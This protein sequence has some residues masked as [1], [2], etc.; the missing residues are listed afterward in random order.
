[1]RTCTARKSGSN[2]GGVASTCSTIGGHMRSPPSPAFAVG[3]V[4]LPATDTRARTE[5]DTG[6][7][8][9]ASLMRGRTLKSGLALGLLAGLVSASNGNAAFP[10]RDG[11]IAFASNRGPPVD[12]PQILADSGGGGRAVILNSVAAGAYDAA[13]SPDGRLIAFFVPQGRSA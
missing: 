10:G 3:V 11:L 6:R 2:S 1:Y 8:S 4:R 9:L 5:P 7:P 12:R 13:P